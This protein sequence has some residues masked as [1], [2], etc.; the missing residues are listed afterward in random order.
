VGLGLRTGTN[1]GVRF[2]GGD[3]IET[4]PTDCTVD[5]G[6]EAGT[7]LIAAASGCCDCGWRVDDGVV[8]VSVVAL[9]VVI[10]GA[11]C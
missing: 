6:A 1:C 2:E 4:G 3:N 8:P 10:V 9:V 11:L 5:V 7:L